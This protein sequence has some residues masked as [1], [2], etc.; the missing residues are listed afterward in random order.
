MS[1][2][3]ENNEFL[4]LSNEHYFITRIFL[5]K[6]GK[7]WTCRFAH[8]KSSRCCQ[9]VF[10]V[11]KTKK[12][13]K[14]VERLSS[15]CISTVLLVAGIPLSLVLGES[16][17]QTGVLY[18]CFW[19]TAQSFCCSSFAPHVAAVFIKR[20]YASFICGSIA[21]ENHNLNEHRFIYILGFIISIYFIKNG[22]NWYRIITWTP[23]K[24]M[25]KQKLLVKMLICDIK[26]ISFWAFID[27][28]PGRL[29]LMAAFS[30]YT[31]R[32]V[33]LPRM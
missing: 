25:T 2:S 33:L 23:Q 11:R 29:S 13:K 10:G 18:C 19:H 1:T 15:S 31:F 9:I 26:S 30:F 24:Y 16:A 5:K 6:N 14:N 17:R 28:L 21:T 8:F 4:T 7:F 32:S 27:C 12:K 22:F 3:R 20:G